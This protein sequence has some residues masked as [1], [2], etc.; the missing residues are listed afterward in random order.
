MKHLNIISGWRNDQ[1]HRIGDQARVMMRA[2]TR[3]RTR[4]RWYAPTQEEYEAYLGRTT[5][6]PD[7]W[8]RGHT[9]LEILPETEPVWREVRGFVVV[10]QDGNQ[11][12]VNNVPT[13]VTFW[14]HRSRV[15][16]PGRYRLFDGGE[17]DT[18][19]VVVVKPGSEVGSHLH[20]EVTEVEE[21][22][23]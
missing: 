3:H 11:Y 23:R 15:F 19:S 14:V 6:M 18:W 7:P 5:R 21:V 4:L 13:G 2:G 8:G 20:V 16:T 17:Y 1:D 12:R 22:G 9:V 10:A